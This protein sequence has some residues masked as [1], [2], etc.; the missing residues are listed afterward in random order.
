M[1][2]CLPTIGSLHDIMEYE[3]S[4]SKVELGN[5]EWVPQNNG[6]IGLSLHK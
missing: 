1:H 2:V 4:I 5:H 6:G 3:S